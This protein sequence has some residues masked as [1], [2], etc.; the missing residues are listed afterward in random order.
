MNK[1]SMDTY[2]GVMVEI[3]LRTAVIDLYLSGRQN[4]GYLATNI[5]VIGL[6]FRKIFELIAL[7]SLAA[8]RDLYSRAYA[9]FAKHWEATKLLENV[10]HINPDF[11]PKPVI[12]EKTAQP[13]VKSNLR[14]RDPDYLTKDELVQAHGRCGSL[15][16]AANP[17]GRGIDYAFFNRCFPEW[18]AKTIN[19]L[20]CHQLHV[21][22][23]TGFYLVHMQE[24]GKDGVTWYKFGR[25][26]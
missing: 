10:R 13:E 3:K 5:E 18:R 14:P 8:H 1:T 2:V 16:H 4:A 15:M 25:S 17:Y 21:P 20:N 9:D 26:D 23:D 24:E 7:S 19:L 11:Y 6:Q 12:E 22:G